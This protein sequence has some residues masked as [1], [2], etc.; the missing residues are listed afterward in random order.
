MATFD[1][2]DFD[3][4]ISWIDSEEM[5]MQFSG[6]TFLFPL[7]KEQLEINL[8]NKNRFAYKVVDLATN[9]MIGYSEI[10]LQDASSALLGRVIIGDA[11]FK[12]KGIGQKIMQNL[13]EISFLQFKVQKAELNVFDWNIIAI[14]CYEKVGF[15]INPGKIKK[16]KIKGETWTALNM[17]IEKNSWNKM[18][19]IATPKL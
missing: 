16:R 15:V 18:Q 19:E 9:S 10:Y 4:L 1:T 11:K 2:R 13:L 8:E 12:R 6:P 5:L 3:K 7:T 17:S 14:K